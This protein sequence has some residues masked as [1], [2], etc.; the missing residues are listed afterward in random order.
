MFLHIHVWLFCSLCD[1]IIVIVIIIIII[2]T[3]AL[4]LAQPIKFQGGIKMGC[5][6]FQIHVF[7]IRKLLLASVE[8]NIGDLK[9]PGWDKLGWLPEVHVLYWA[10]ARKHS[11]HLPAVLVS[12][13]TSFHPSSHH[14][15]NMSILL[16]FC[17][18]N[19]QS[20]LDAMFVLCL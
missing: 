1:C 7:C 18:T 2:I 10:C 17:P 19:V 9:I 4:S 11:N 20:E 15:E 14:I 12:S 3:L 13:R 5:S 6:C 16:L 8:E